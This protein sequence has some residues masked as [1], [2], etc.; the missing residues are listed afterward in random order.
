MNSHRGPDRE[1]KRLF[2]RISGKHF[3]REVFRAQL[4]RKRFLVPN[5]VTLANLFCGFLSIVYSSS[6]RF[7]HAA[8]A[9]GIAI[10]LDGLD[11]RVARRLNATS[12]F[13]LE[14]DSFSDLVSFGL[15][16]ALLVYNW[17]LRTSADEFGVIV[18]FLFA[19]AAA[20]RL[21]RFNTQPSSLK[22]FCGLPT[23]AAAGFVAAS[24]RAVSVE[25]WG[26]FEI[27]LLVATI[28]GLAFLMVSNVPFFSPKSVTITRVSARL[29]AAM[30][31]VIALLWYNDRIGLFLVALAYVASGPILLAI[32]GKASELRGESESTAQP[33]LLVKDE[34]DTDPHLPVQ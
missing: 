5:A 27:S 21:A 22:A 8:V 25:S 18:C 34:D 23:P 13:G 28:V 29:T 30:G 33:D 20:G 6:G 1:K 15:A 11:G 2:R 4:H 19:L 32:R 9:I 26:R 10:L 31:A 17:A 3:E 14:F 12:A 7:E 16:P 24:V